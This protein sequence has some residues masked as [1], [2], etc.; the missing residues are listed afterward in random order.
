VFWAHHVMHKVNK[1]VMIHQPFYYYYQRDDSIVATYTPEN[2]DI[3]RGLR[4]R[5][6]FIEKYYGDLTDESYKLILKTCFI[7]Y[8]L[9][10]LNRKIDDKGIYRKEIKIYIRSHLQPFKQAVQNNQQLKRQLFL[11]NLH[12]ALMIFFQ[13][14]ITGLRKM[15][16][17]SGPV[18]LKQVDVS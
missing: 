8:H 6:L 18:G 9:L 1:Y 7:H 14:V 17:L 5:H 10:K 15:K 2:L 3:I 4:E 12:P 13:R 11:F 16:L